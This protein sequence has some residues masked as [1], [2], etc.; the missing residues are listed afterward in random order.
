M[1]QSSLA[2]VVVGEL[3][4]FLCLYLLLQ[5]M[6]IP[7][8]SSTAAVN[9]NSPPANAV[10]AVTSLRYSSLSDNICISLSSN[11]LSVDVSTEFE[12]VVASSGPAI[13]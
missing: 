9:T 13:D 8:T 10:G 1:S 2:F 3:V 12:V 6:I 11:E 4:D 7:A 5:H